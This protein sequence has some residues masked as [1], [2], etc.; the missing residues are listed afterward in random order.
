[1]SE[2]WKTCAWYSSKNGL[3]NPVK[4]CLQ[5]QARQERVERIPTTWGEAGELEEDA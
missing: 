1:M 4:G 3:L 2:L 5:I